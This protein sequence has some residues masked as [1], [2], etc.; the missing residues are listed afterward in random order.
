MI[1]DRYVKCTECGHRVIMSAIDAICLHC[2]KPYSYIEYNMLWLEQSHPNREAMEKMKENTVYQCAKCGFTF[3]SITGPLSH[4][5]IPKHCDLTMVDKR[6][7]KE[8]PVKKISTVHQVTSL[9]LMA[10]GTT[11]LDV[12]AEIN[13]K[14]QTIHIQGNY[15]VEK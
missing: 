1:D 2:G 8:N 14:R 12:D 4:D 11:C 6:F 15:Q 3:T 13:G 5:A 7:I 9:N 10:D